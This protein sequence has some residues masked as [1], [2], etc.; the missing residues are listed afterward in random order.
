M[1]HHALLLF[2][3]FMSPII[4]SQAADGAPP[5]MLRYDGLYRSE[6]HLQKPPLETADGSR[7]AAFVQYA[8]FYA[9]GTFITVGIGE[10]DPRQPTSPDILLRWFNRDHPGISRG[11]WRMDGQSVHMTSI[12]KEGE[13][14]YEGRLLGDTLTLR[15]HSF[16]NQRDGVQTYTFVPVAALAHNGERNDAP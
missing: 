2:G 15:W 3:L 13:V 12:S 7:I 14:R 4:A 10:S 1:R 9:D 16:I 5:P 8:R 11:V 6:P